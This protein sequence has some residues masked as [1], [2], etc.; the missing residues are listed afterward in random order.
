MRIIVKVL[1]KNCLWLSLF[2]KQQVSEVTSS[3]RTTYPCPDDTLRK[4]LH[5]AWFKNQ[6]WTHKYGIILEFVLLASS[7]SPRMA[8]DIQ[9]VL[10]VY[11]TTSSTI[12]TST[13]DWIPCFKVARMYILYCIEL[14]SLFLYYI[15][16]YHCKLWVCTVWEC[17]QSAAPASSERQRSGGLEMLR[18]TPRLELGGWSPGDVT[19]TVFIRLLHLHSPFPHFMFHFWL[20]WKYTVFHLSPIYFQNKQTTKIKSYI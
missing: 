9:S 2:T 20:T 8:I 6:C 13:F 19:I 14:H 5:T 18:H 15:Y 11:I 4:Y 1:T 3:Q 12:G 7:P 10:Y 17:C 16:C